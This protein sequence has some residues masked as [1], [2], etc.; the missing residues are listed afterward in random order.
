MSATLPVDSRATAGSTPAATILYAE[1]D[2]DLRPLSALFLARAGFRVTPVCDGREAWEK[3]HAERYDLLVT[4]NDMP[5]LTGLELVRKARCEG[6]GI[7]V[8]LASSPAN[9][10]PEWLRIN[11]Q[12]PKPFMPGELV[13]AARRV[14]A[15]ASCRRG[16]GPFVTPFLAALAGEARGLNSYRHW[17]INE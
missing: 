7:P 11:A 12:V 13:V 6:M 17:G 1:D 16:D 4:D 15:G 9:G 3:L 2:P 5:R 14:L 8:I 10:G